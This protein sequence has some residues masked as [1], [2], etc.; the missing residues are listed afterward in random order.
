MIT[1][2]NVI[3]ALTFVPHAKMDM[4][5]TYLV[6]AYKIKLINAILTDLLHSAL[7]VKSPI[8]LWTQRSVKDLIQAVLMK[9]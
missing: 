8:F 1:A 4:N 9:I 5:L 3:Q 2:S 6:N 7:S